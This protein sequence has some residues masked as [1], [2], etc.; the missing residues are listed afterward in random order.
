[1]TS[2]ADP[3]K[4]AA[5]DAFVEVIREETDPWRK[6]RLLAFL[7]KERWHQ[8]LLEEA[9]TAYEAE[10][11][12]DEC[13]RQCYWAALELITEPSPN[14]PAEGPLWI[15]PVSGVCFVRIYPGT[16]NMG[17]NEAF[18]MARPIHKVTIRREY[19]IARHPLTNGEYR[20]YLDE[21]PD[22][23]KSEM[24]NHP[25]FNGSGQPVLGVSWEEAQNGYCGWLRDQTDHPIHLPT[26]A[27][28]EYACRA[29]SQERFCF[30]DG[31]EEL[32]SYAWYGGSKLNKKDSSHPVGLKRPNL[33]GLQDVHGNVWEWCWDWFANYPREAQHDPTGPHS[34]SV[35]VFRGGS[36]FGSAFYAR[37]ANRI[38][39]TPGP[40]DYGVGFRPARSSVGRPE[41]G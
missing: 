36:W 24:P 12:R 14:P 16:F 32:S 3:T 11:D 1:M 6:A 25:R 23:R 34:G 13:Y 28:W 29:G 22:A 37:C 9:L 39:G 17:S 38:N 18:D 26:E 27:E 10:K 20:R 40:S 8:G 33:W 31:E 5:I 2:P 15:E 19:W 7:R 30:G 4:T 35:R 41:A 21:N